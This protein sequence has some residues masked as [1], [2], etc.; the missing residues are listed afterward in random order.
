MCNA[1]GF[2][3]FDLEDLPVHVMTRFTRRSPWGAGVGVL[4]DWLRWLL[5]APAVPVLGAH[6]DNSADSLGTTSA[7]IAHA[8]INVPSSN[9]VRI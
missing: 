5:L 8:G 6:R 7:R 9:S 3:D 4:I 2:D 1:S